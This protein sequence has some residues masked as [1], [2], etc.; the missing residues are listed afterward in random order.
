MIFQRRVLWSFLTAGF[1][2]A[3]VMP[4]V[5]VGE[6]VSQESA[7]DLRARFSLQYHPAG[8]PGGDK[9]PQQFSG[10]LEWRHQAKEDDLLFTDPLGQGVAQLRRPR[11]G[12]VELRLANG[13]RREAETVDQLLET[14]LGISLPFDDLLPW[15]QAR[16]GSGALV[17]KDEQGRPWRVRESGWLL[18]YQYADESARLPAR[19]D[20]SL[21]G[22]VVKLRLLFESWDALP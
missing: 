21:D 22:G 14:A 12:P 1:L 3:C 13:E 10:R 7:F 4:P 11:Q 20:A 9:R 17:E 18:S 16:P 2:S 6:G 8:F 15:V 19:L 5:Q